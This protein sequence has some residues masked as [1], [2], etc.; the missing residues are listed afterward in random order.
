[1]FRQALKVYDTSNRAIIFANGSV[2]F[3][4]CPLPWGEVSWTT[5][6]KGSKLKWNQHCDQN[7]NSYFI[8]TFRFDYEQE[9]EYE[10]DFRISNQWCLHFMLVLGG[11]GSSWDEIGM[12][13]DNVRPA[14]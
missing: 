12:G 11:E 10:Y 2:K 5:E 14:K 3:H 13:H 6:A 1:M 9:I 8:E 7:K 4:A